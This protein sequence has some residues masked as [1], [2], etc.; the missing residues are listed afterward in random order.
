MIV[1]HARLCAGHPERRLSHGGGAMVRQIALL[2]RELSL[3]RTAPRP[4]RHVA[5]ELADAMDRLYVLSRHVGL[6]AEWEAKVIDRFAEIGTRAG[7]HMSE[8]RFL[9]AEPRALKRQGG[10]V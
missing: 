10:G 7:G 8:T 2:L 5:L 1:R 9:A 3:S 6:A 4:S